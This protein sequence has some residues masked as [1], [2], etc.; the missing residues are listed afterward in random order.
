MQAFSSSRPGYPFSQSSLGSGLRL[1]AFPSAKKHVLPAHARMRAARRQRVCAGYG[2]M[3]AA[4][5]LRV[6]NARCVC[7]QRNACVSLSLSLARSLSVCCLARK[8]TSVV[9][10]PDDDLPEE[11]HSRHCCARLSNVLPHISTTLPPSAAPKPDAKRRSLRNQRR[12]VQGGGNWRGD[13]EERTLES[14]HAH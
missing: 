13:T 9:D 7:V 6:L 11:A 3:R 5:R 12:G 4:M 10:E 2:R 14:A 1:G 8:L